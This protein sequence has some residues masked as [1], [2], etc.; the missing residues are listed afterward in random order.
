MNRFH[1]RLLLPLGAIALA[2]AVGCAGKHNDTTATTGWQGPTP[3]ES[4][5]GMTS[6]FGAGTVDDS[7]NI[8][9]VW[10]RSYDRNDTGGLWGNYRDG[11][12]SWEAES[13]GPLGLPEA[14]GWGF[15]HPLTMGFLSS[16]DLHP[17]LRATGEGAFAFVFGTSNGLG[18]VVWAG[19]YQRNSGMDTPV[20][21]STPKASAFLPSLAS[22]AQGQCA[23][24]WVENGRATVAT[25]EPSGN[26]WSAPVV[27]SSLS[28]TLDPKVGMDSHGNIVAAWLEDSSTHPGLYK[29][30]ASRYSV[31]T[32]SWSAPATIQAGSTGSSRYYDLAMS[33]AGAMLAW[34][35]YTYNPESGL[36]LC[37]SSLSPSRDAWSSPLQLT[38]L[39]RDADDPAVCM[40]AAGNAV[41]AWGERGL[42]WH[43]P[44][45]LWGASFPSLT[46]GFGSLS[47]F[48]VDTDGHALDGFGTVVATN[49]SGK[50]ALAF[51]LLDDDGIPR[52]ATALYDGSWGKVTLMQTPGVRWANAPSLSMNDHGTVLVLWSQEETGCQGRTYANIYSPR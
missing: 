30:M 19:R 38:S 25:Y 41:V 22:N 12:G 10:K 8:L 51:R 37:V 46:S 13:T 23:A 45:E 47:T 35:E 50:A 52:V 39:Y 36:Q 6:L 49:A 26:T 11:S 16:S 1:F 4:T 17:S 3:L 20:Q 44:L 33:D 31:A 7:G 9:A 48:K 28:S 14:W 32:G 2:L 5:S 29:V 42:D 27:V 15:G 21:L 34:A 24:I 18:N 40:N 43:E